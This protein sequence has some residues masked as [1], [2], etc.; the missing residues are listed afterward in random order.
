[1]PIARVCI[2]CGTD[3]ARVA[4]ATEP[5]Y[6]WLVRACPTCAAIMPERAVRRMPRHVAAWIRLV[7]FALLTFVAT[8]LVLGGT[9]AHE[10][11]IRDVYID[12]RSWL[13]GRWRAASL[14]HIGRFFSD[15][16]DGPERIAVTV[17]RVVAG[18]FAGLWCLLLPSR[19]RFAASLLSLGAFAC[20]LPM[21]GIIVE[22]ANLA[23]ASNVFNPRELA[24]DL[25]SVPISVA[26]TLA[27]GAMLWRAREAVVRSASKAAARRLARLRRARKRKRS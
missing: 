5:R 13:D 9:F 1:M 19:R 7:V 22:R 25:A 4:P 6:R 16:V 27:P 2:A 26:I 8:L 14:E 3:L 11:T 17:V 23:A 24:L 15:E 21:T 10:Q 18:L 20:A 12:T